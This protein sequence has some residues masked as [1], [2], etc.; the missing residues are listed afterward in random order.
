MMSKLGARRGFTL[1]EVMCGILVLA[2]S[3]SLLFA[4]IGAAGS[5]NQRARQSQEN[6]YEELSV[7]EG[8]STAIAEGKA[9]FFAVDASGSSSS[10]PYGERAVDV[11][12]KTGET[13]KSYRLRP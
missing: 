5:I 12:A 4:G 8:Y 6:F 1:I 7:A 11:Y 9:Q 2:F 10:S 13:L 3:G